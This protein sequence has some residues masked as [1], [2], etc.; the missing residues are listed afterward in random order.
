[1]VCV[2]GPDFCTFFW[3]ITYLISSSLSCVLYCGE[4]RHLSCT[5]DT[6][7]V[8]LPSACMKKML[9]SLSCRQAWPVKT[10]ATG[11]LGA[12]AT[13]KIHRILDFHRIPLPLWQRLLHQAFS[14]ALNPFFVPPGPSLHHFPSDIFRSLTCQWVSV[15]WWPNSDLALRLSLVNAPSL[16]GQ[17]WGS[18]WAESWSPS[19]CFLP[20]SLRTPSCSPSQDAWALESDNVSLNHNLWPSGLVMNFTEALITSSEKWDNNTVCT[21]NFIIYLTQIT[22][23]MRK[24]FFFEEFSEINS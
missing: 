19:F 6:V 14:F 9:S 16:M 11:W 15:L 24:V 17:P 18:L 12:L 3:N 13:P 23:A 20:A 2:S 21:V 8:C 1:M 4:V 5:S 22:Y 7:G 10:L